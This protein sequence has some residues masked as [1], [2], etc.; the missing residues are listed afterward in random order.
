MSDCTAMELPVWR[1]EPPPGQYVEFCAANRCDCT[2]AG[3]PVLQWNDEIRTVLSEV[4]R[5]VNAEIIFVPDWAFWG[6][7]DRWSYPTA[8]R[9]DC[10]DF[11][12]EKR[13]RLV[14]EGVPSAALT[15]AIAHHVDDYY[16]HAVLLV[17]TTAGTFV[18]DN[19]QDELQ[20]WDSPPYRYERRERP[21]GQ[22]TRF[23]RGYE[24][25][26]RRRQ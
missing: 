6:V 8:G 1:L 18:L 23:E 15:L 16:P 5:K 21:D 4:N 14:M 10:E 11:A 7:E 22:W 24:H 17:E 26:I 2:L 9:G 19:R 20:C 3:E 25:P 13:R 12:L